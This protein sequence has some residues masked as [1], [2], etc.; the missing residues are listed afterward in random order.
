MSYQKNTYIIPNSVT[1]IEEN[2]FRYCQITS[3]TLPDDL[4]V[5]GSYAFSGCYSLSS[6]SIPS[7]VQYIGDYAFSDCYDLTTVKFHSRLDQDFF[8][9]KEEAFK[10]CD[11]IEKIYVPVGY[12]AFYTS[13]YALREYTDKI[14]EFIALMS[15]SKMSASSQYMPTKVKDKSEQEKMSSIKENTEKRSQSHNTRMENIQ[16]RV[17]DR[18]KDYND[19]ISSLDES[20]SIWAEA[21]KAELNAEK[22]LEPINYEETTLDLEKEQIEAR[23]E[24]LRK[25]KAEY[26][27]L[28]I[29]EAKNAAPKFGL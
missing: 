28:C 13:I 10:K 5:I 26:D 6:L 7:K 18:Y 23:L 9:I 29:E 17:A 14:E 1:H 12:K 20:V 22:D 16:Q 15:E 4:I 11:N 19:S 25:E 8:I 24:I 2:A 3:V 27:K 21:R